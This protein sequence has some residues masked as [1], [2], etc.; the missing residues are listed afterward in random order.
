M[1]ATLQQCRRRSAA[2][3]ALAVLASLCFAPPAMADASLQ[4]AGWDADLKLPE[5]VD[6]NPD[7]RIVEINLEARVA[8]G[9][10]GRASGRGVDL[11]RR[12]ARAA[13]SCPRRRSPDRPLLE[14]A[15]AADDGALARRAGAD[16]DGRRARSIRSPRCGRAS[17]SPTTSS[18]PTPGLYWYHPHVMSAAQVGFGLYGALLV[19]DPAE[20]VGV[21]DELVLVLSES[22]ST[23]T[24][25]SSRRT[26]AAR[27]AWRSAARATTCS[28][29]AGSDRRADRAR[30]AL[31][32]AG[33]S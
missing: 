1:I 25:S 33:G 14:H 24:A 15:A 28:S 6:T 10:S 2:A 9:R 13:D 18:C 32:S 11:Q 19:E 17:R 7:P 16:S 23:T 5:A 3:A 20:Q 30:T 29:M 26:A 8:H 22:A 21:A 12:H 27:P 31:R 4:P